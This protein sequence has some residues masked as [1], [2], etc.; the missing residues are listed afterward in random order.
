M[1]LAS[2][3]EVALLVIKKDTDIGTKTTKHNPYRNEI[4]AKFDVVY[5]IMVGISIK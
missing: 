3:I 1:L 2:V 4:R 5:T